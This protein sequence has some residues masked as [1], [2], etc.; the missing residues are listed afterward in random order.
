MLNYWNKWNFARYSNFL[1]MTCMF[2]V[3]VSVCVCIFVYVL[4]VNKCVLACLFWMC[5]YILNV[6]IVCV[7]LCVRVSMCL[8]ILYVYICVCVCVCGCVC[9]CVCACMCVCVHACVCACISWI[10]VCVCVYVYVPDGGSSDVRRG[11]HGGGGV[12]AGCPAHRQLAA[13]PPTQ[14]LALRLALHQPAEG[15]EVACQQETDRQSDT[16]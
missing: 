13:V 10:C 9:V 5:I 11:V 12:P 6:Y 1:S 4:S 14:T 16:C 3:C 15:G 8:C 2:C 7:Y